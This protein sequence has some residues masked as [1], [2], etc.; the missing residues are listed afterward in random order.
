VR[1]DEQMTESPLE[2]VLQW[3]AAGAHWRTGRMGDAEAEIV[4]LAGTGETVDGF[5]SSDP[6]L[7]AYLR[8]RPSSEDDPPTDLEEVTPA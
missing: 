8:V 2:R 1:D 3:E 7:L 6:T 5:V 4:L